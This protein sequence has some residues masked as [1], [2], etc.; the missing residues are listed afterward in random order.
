MRRLIRH[1][2]VA[3]AL[4]FIVCSLGYYAS[5]DAPPPDDE[6]LRLPEPEVPDEKNAWTYFLKAGE[7]ARWPDVNYTQQQLKSLMDSTWWDKS[8]AAEWVGK[9]EQALE[10]W[11][12]GLAQEVCGVAADDKVASASGAADLWPRMRSVAKAA[13]LRAVY[14]H[15]SGKHAEAFDE[16]LRLVRFGRLLEGSRAYL[17]GYLM[18][19]SIMARGTET[20]Y[21]FLEDAQLPPETLKKYA[22]KLERYQINHTGLEVTFRAEY[23]FAIKSQ[24]ALGSPMRRGESGFWLQRGPDVGLGGLFWGKNRISRLLAR[25]ARINIQNVPRPWARV[26]YSDMPGW[27]QEMKTWRDAVGLLLSGDP[28]GRIITGLLVPAFK[29]VQKAKCRRELRVA[30]IRTLLALKTYKMEHGDLPPSLEALVPTYLDEVPRDPFDGKSLRYSREKNIL[31]SVG[32]DLE[33]N[34]GSSNMDDRFM[35]PDPT[36]KIQF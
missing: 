12:K 24:E 29:R 21:E 35:M 9:N 26:D 34:G 28:L 27:P 23:E 25:I 16:C 6:D 10:T 2:C 17:L 31:Y 1:L 30:A 15:K 8:F 3:F 19:G 22:E 14:L 20:W 13:N 32:E 4:G 7:E 11:R 33:D 36:Y 5:I 18:A